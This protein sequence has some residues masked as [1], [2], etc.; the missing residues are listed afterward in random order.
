M[1]YYHEMSLTLQRNVL[2]I[3][4]IFSIFS[5]LDNITRICSTDGECNPGELCVIN[6]CSKKFFY[7][8]K[9]GLFFFPPM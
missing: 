2:E 4:K 3:R 1:L 5:I 7:F 8:S 9:N 6:R